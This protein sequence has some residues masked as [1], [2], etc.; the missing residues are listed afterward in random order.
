MLQ[1]WK[2]GA[3]VLGSGMLRQRWSSR[4]VSV[5]MGSV[6]FPVE[7]INICREIFEGERRMWCH[8]DGN[9]HI[10]LAHDNPALR[11][12]AENFVCADFGEANEGDL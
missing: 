11:L 7:T 12:G 10:A 9:V 8:T 2:V 4:R 5:L 6:G 3:T 1:V